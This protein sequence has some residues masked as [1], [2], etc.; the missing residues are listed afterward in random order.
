VDY[1]TDNEAANIWP[2]KPG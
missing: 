1:T 2:W